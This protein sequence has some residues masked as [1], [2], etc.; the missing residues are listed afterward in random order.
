MTFLYYVLLIVSAAAL[1]A[2]EEKP[3][4][5]AVGLALICTSLI[6]ALGNLGLTAVDPPH[7]GQTIVETIQTFWSSKLA[8]LPLL[9][10]ILLFAVRSTTQR[11]PS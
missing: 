1:A 8:T 5:Q 3:V 2:S 4:W 10:T 7:F 6:G 9:S 11:Q